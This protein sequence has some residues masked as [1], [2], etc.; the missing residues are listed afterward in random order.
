MKALNH[1][2]AGRQ[3]FKVNF[4][5]QN[6]STIVASC[7]DYVRYIGPC[8]KAAGFWGVIIPSTS[9]FIAQIRASDRSFQERAVGE[10]I[11]FRFGPGQECFGHRVP[12]QDPRLLHF[13]GAHEDLENPS[14]SSI[15]P[16]MRRNA[17]PWAARPF[18]EK[19]HEEIIKREELLRQEGLVG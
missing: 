1:D 3:V 4:D 8:D 13:D 14:T 12:T 7:R 17:K 16:V 18:M 5:Q 19:L 2:P 9:P 11:E 15:T 10:Q 6:A